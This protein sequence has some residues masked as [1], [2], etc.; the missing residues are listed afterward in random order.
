VD[1]AGTLP[2]RWALAAGRASSKGCTICHG[3]RLPGTRLCGPCKA[4]LKRARLETVSDLVPLPSRATAEAETARRRAK[5]AA[6]AAAHSAAPRRRRRLLT[7]VFVLAGAALVA[8]GYLALRIA[9]PI[10]ESPVVS[11]PRAPRSVPLPAVPTPRTE[12]PVVVVGSAAKPLA[13]PPVAL[14][15]GASGVSPPRSAQK[16]VAPAP[17]ALGAPVDRFPAATEPVVVAP[18]AAADLVPPAREAPAPDR[19]QVMADQIARCGREGFLAGVVCE[20]R[21][22]LKYCEGYWGVAAQCASGI[23]NDHGR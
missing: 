21:V 3:P 11:V 19:W 5:A 10:V 20:Q 2:D 16:R 9:G 12:A 1:R 14:P 6:A 22:R 18:V 15:H 13:E 8:G 7:P 4:A 17:A 23:P